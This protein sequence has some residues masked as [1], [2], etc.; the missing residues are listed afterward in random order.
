MSTN[1]AIVDRDQAGPRRR[2]IPS[3]AQA[4]DERTPAASQQPRPASELE[5]RVRRI[6]RRDLDRVWRF[7]KLVFRDVN[8]ETVEYQRP[9]LK[10]HFYQIYEEAGVEQLLF[11]MKKNAKYELVGY[12]E[13]T[14]EIAGS[15]NWMNQ[16]YFERRSMRPLF[17]EE[18][19]V[20]PDYHNMGIGSF[21]YEQIEHAAKLRGCTHIVLEVAENNEQALEFYRSRNFAKLD[22]AIFLAR[23]LE[24]E[25]ELLPP[26]RIKLR[27]Q[28]A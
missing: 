17:V 21:M 22:A 15:D 26:R 27:R 11:E 14:Y 8:R 13:Y 25:Q 24:Q 3:K 19:A 1:L 10:R 28:Q 18:L 16:R 12:A 2:G 5:L 6:H 7:L 20:H 9:R 23:K 4:M